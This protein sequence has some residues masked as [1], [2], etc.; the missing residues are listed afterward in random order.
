MSNR[1]RD[2][3]EYTPMILKLLRNT[4]LSYKD[5]AD[6]IQYVYGTE[7]GKG[8]I[9]YLKRRERIERPSENVIQPSDIVR[10]FQAIVNTD[11]DI[12]WSD[13]LDLE[14]QPE[15]LYDIEQDLIDDLEVLGIDSETSKKSR[16]SQD[17]FV[18]IESIKQV[19]KVAKIQYKNKSLNEN[20][21]AHFKQVL[22]FIKS[23]QK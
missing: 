4:T 23:I 1:G 21:Q 12:V 10:E 5:V 9:G 17:N 13:N 2:E 18:P 19:L 3:R 6:H 14:E 15:P 22:D 7:I 8:T 11:A 20:Y 16:D